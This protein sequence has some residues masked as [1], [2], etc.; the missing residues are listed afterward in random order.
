MSASIRFNSPSHAAPAASPIGAVPI[1]LRPGFVVPII[2]R[3]GFRFGT[4]ISS[5]AAAALSAI[6]VGIPLIAEIEIPRP[7]R[8][9]RSDGQSPAHPA[10]ADPTVRFVAVVRRIIVDFGA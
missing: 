5:D 6:A 2:L 8:R 9:R 7:E 10:A 4:E 1:I 3:P